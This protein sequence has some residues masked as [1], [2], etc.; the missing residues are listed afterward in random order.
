V[1]IEVS[2]FQFAHLWRSG[3][4]NACGFIAPDCEGADADCEQIYCYLCSSYAGRS[5]AREETSLCY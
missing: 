5:N 1:A 4:L 2:L 3:D